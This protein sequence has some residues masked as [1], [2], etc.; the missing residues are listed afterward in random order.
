MW[1][2]AVIKPQECEGDHLQMHPKSDG[3]L[4]LIEFSGH[5]P[6]GNVWEL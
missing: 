6:L 5:V 3:V 2:A 4:P 1:L